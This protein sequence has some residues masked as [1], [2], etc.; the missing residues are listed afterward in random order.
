MVADC[1]NSPTYLEPSNATL[2]RLID[3]RCLVT[4]Y[5][6]P[7]TMVGRNVWPSFGPPASH[8]REQGTLLLVHVEI[9]M[10]SSGIF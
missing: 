7:K 4:R 9:V 1:L 10:Q 2:Y 8:I 5:R 3:H 6:Y